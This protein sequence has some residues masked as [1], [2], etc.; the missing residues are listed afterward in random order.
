MGDAPQSPYSTISKSGYAAHHGFTWRFL[1]DWALKNAMRRSPRSHVPVIIFKKCDEEFPPVA[2]YGIQLF[3][4]QRLRGTMLVPA[5]RGTAEITSAL[6][7]RLL[8]IWYS[9]FSIEIQV[10]QSRGQILRALRLED[11]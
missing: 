6:L 4:V 2:R 7:Q 10:L 5:L 1:A 3:R 11:Q 8:I 9:K